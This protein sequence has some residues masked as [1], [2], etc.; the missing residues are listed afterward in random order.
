M[1]LAGR[2]A[3]VTGGARGIGRGIVLAL[4]RRGAHVVVADLLADPA[5]DDAAEETI[6]RARSEGVD[7]LALPCDVRDPVQVEALVSAVIE[8]FGHVDIGC[9][10]A[11]VIRE[12]SLADGSVGDWRLMLDVNLTGS[13]LLVKSLTPHLTAQ[14]SGALLMVSSIAAFR[15]GTHYTAYCASKAGLI[16]LTRATATE[17]APHGVRANAICPGYL[18]TSMWYTDILP[19]MGEGDM[20]EQFRSVVAAAVPLG[21]PQ[22]PEDIGHAAVYLCEADNVTGIALAV[23]GGHLAGP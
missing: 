7:A 23:D 20:D 14:R 2:V 11:G 15:G 10:N 3:I 5:V 22:T 6:A 17:L 12:S 9:A 1:H 16:G 13:F 8:R 18:A 21:R 4:A 19:G